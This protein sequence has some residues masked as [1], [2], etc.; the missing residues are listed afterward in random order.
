MAEAIQIPSAQL[1]ALTTI[2]DLVRHDRARTRPEL[3]RATGLGRA[4]VTQRVSELIEIGLVESGEQAP[5][6]GGRAPRRL[7]FNANLGHLLVADIGATHVAVAATDLSGT[8]L[9]TAREQARVDTGPE[10]ILD[11]V[12]GLF[13]QVASAVP[14]RL[15]GIG[16]GVPGPVEFD[17]GRPVAPPI[18]PGWDRFPI[19]DAFVQDYN[20]PVWVDNDVN[21]MA[22][23]EARAGVAQGHQ[24]VLFVKVGTGIGAGLIIDGELRRGAQGC[25]GDIG[26]VE[27]DARHTVV[28]RCGNVGCLEAVAGGAALARDGEA[29]ARSGQSPRLAQI[30]AEKGHVEAVDVAWAGSHG[31]VASLDLITSAGAVIGRALAVVVNVLNPSLIVIGGGVSGAGEP[32]AASIREVVYGRSLP[33]ATRELVIRRSTLGTDA[34]IRGAAA[35]V[36]GELFSSRWLARWL[37]FGEPAA[38]L[39]TSLEQ[40]VAS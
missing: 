23:G 13:G 32:F 28:C 37:R 31:C 30:L 20:A 12:R 5:S 22:L 10:A 24:N 3:E 11:T 25:A 4:V 17:S 26:H 33:L 7:K 18:M 27:T 14:G 2:L 36:T 38:A 8:L 21:I 1:V 39:A 16:I 35:M 9:A 6:T 19:R 40:P 34:G 15:W 29:L